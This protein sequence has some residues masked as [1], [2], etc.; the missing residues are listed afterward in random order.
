MS[1]YGRFAAAGAIAY[2]V[3]AGLSVIPYPGI[4]QDEAL[5]A[6]GL[7]DPRHVA[8][9]F[10]FHGPT[11]A[12]LMSY[13][14]AL[15][16]WL[17]AVV[18]RVWAP[19]VWSVRVPMLAAA[20]AALWLLWLAVRRTCGDFAAAAA[21]ALAAT[22][23]VFLLTAVFD[24]GPVALQ[25]LLAMG[26]AAGA[27]HYVQTS[28][29][30][31]LGAAGFLAGLGL[32]DKAIFAW[33]LGGSALALAL[34]YGARLRKLLPLRAAVLALIMLAIGA[35]PLIRY[36][37]R[38]PWGT[39]RGNVSAEPNDIPGRAN[40][41]R[42]TLDG[43]AL[44]GWM[45][46]QS[47]PLPQGALVWLSV[48][49]AAALPWMGAWRRPALL[50]L[51]G[52]VFSWLP[53]LFTARTGG[54]AHHTILLW[55][56]A[57]CFVSMAA[58][59]LESRQWRGVAIGLVMVCCA[60]NIRVLLAYRSD[61]RANGPAPAWTDAV[62]P[63]AAKVDRERPAVVFAND[64]G[65]GEPLRLL[66][67]G[68]IPI[69]TGYDFVFGPGDSIAARVAE[70]NALHIGFVPGRR[71]FPEADARIQAEAERAGFRRELVS[72]IP[73]RRGHAVYEI[74]RFEK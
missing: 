1:R 47:G 66:T 71:A 23:A 26:A 67:A 34:T 5:F 68:R 45:A 18:F 16:S 8:D 37:V 29:T 15:K 55:P 65:F 58:A 36:N 42:W 63:L 64:W 43:R 22:D 35:S 14:G 72:V 10:Q 6:A 2:F 21:V 12:M 46:E 4:A 20:A 3:A 32:W 49:S 54:G 56:L 39:F 60:S 52:F 38:D 41:L 13:V 51:L 25:H 7:Y 40:L 11:P 62:F 31:W 53:M 57:A 44:Q 24:W 59:W 30:R 9:T 74:Y 17:Y 61:L 50:F 73:D 19:G 69:V 48:V 33:L 27:V 70:P 28:R